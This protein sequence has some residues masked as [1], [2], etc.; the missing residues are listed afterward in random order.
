MSL[1]W[2]S[3]WIFNLS[4]LKYTM[5]SQWT[6]YNATNPGSMY[7]KWKLV[8]KFFDLI[9]KWLKVLKRLEKNKALQRWY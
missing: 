8:L 9:K 2:T 7:I 4:L 3:Y 1:F 6:K 5:Y